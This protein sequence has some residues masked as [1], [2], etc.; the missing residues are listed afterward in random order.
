V[1]DSITVINYLLSACSEVLQVL[2]S[3]GLCG[4]DSWVGSFEWLWLNE[5]V[6]VS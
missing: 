3:N 4:H 2:S 1:F 5:S 6:L